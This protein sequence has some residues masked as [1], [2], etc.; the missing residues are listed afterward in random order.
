MSLDKVMMPVPDPHPD[1]FDREWPLRVADI[2]ATGRLRLDAACRH[3]QDIGGDQLREMGFQEIHPL[4]IV[5][6]TMVDLIRPIEFHDML[7][8]RRWCSGTSNRWCEMRVR[9]DGRKGG[10]IES[11]AF[12]ININRETQ[13]PARIADDFLEGLRRT[14]DVDRLRWK[15]YLK[16]GQRDAADEIR[17][18]PIRFTDID[19]FDHVN[20]S[21][22]WSVVE[23]YLAAS[24][25][26][27]RGPTR[28]VI[29]HD[30]AVALGEKLEIA[31]QVHPPGSTDQFGEELAKKTVTT[32]TYLVGDET[33][34]VASIFSL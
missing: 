11:E 34:A 10:L 32:L 1:V 4:W 16:P 22:Y 26:L 2:D 23:D 33:K 17:E 19:L 20:N 30:A 5:R 31:A 27:L 29:E 18:F 7:R 3:I 6:R 8:L 13:G 12:W 28:I 14:T 21:V 24:P 15:A 9:V 25:E